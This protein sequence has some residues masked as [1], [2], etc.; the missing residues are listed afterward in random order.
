M[1]NFVQMTFYTKNAINIVSGSAVA[2]CVYFCLVDLHVL[3]LF[4]ILH[5]KERDLSLVA[6]QY[7]LGT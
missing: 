5:G 2:E 3:L 6:S 4:S 1:I 7:S